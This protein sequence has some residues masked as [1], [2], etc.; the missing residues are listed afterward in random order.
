[1]YYVCV[2][3]DSDLDRVFRLPP[4]TFIGGNEQ[5]LPLREIIN[6]LEV[7]KMPPAVKLTNL[8]CPLMG[9]RMYCLIKLKH[10]NISLLLTVD[11]N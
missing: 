1:M 10:L 3:D 5:E 6:R 11:E 7:C 9:S 8:P 4:I 2:L